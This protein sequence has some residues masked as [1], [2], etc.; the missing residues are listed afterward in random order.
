MTKQERK[1]NMKYVENIIG[2]VKEL[3]WTI[4]KIWVK[5]NCIY[6]E[7]VKNNKDRVEEG[8]YAGSDINPQ[9]VYDVFS[10]LKYNFNFLGI[11]NNDDILI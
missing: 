7:R 6:C 11:L 9:N 8:L 3:K 10:L 1:E 2:V 5:D 4:S